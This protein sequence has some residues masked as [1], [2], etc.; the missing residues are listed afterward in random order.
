MKVM[1]GYNQIK[2]AVCNSSRDCPIAY[3][4]KTQTGEKNIAVGKQRIYIQSDAYI[5]SPEVVDWIEALDRHR[6]VH[7]I[8]LRLEDG[9]AKVIRSI[10]KTKMRKP[11]SR[12]GSIE[13]VS[14]E[15]L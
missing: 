12:K 2:T 11:F 6:P 13:E 14:D 8:W 3:A 1:V 7:G 15:T 10:G 4:I 5:N 9:K